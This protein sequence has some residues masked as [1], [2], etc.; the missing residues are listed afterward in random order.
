[1]VRSLNS[2]L[3]HLI[4]IFVL[5]FFSCQTKA[6][7]YKKEFTDTEK[8]QLVENLINGRG[9]YYQGT[10]A[11]Q[12]LLFEAMSYDS[13]HA[14]I[15]RELGV[16]YL[17]R[18]IAS[19]FPHYYG[20]AADLNPL[21]WLAW[22]GYLYLYFYRDYENA[23][24]D[25]LEADELTPGVVDYPQSLNIDFLKGI[26]YLKMGNHQN[27]INFFDKQINYES[28]EVGLEYMESIAF[29]Y[30]GIAHWEMGKK[31]TAKD[32]FEIGQKVDN[33]NADLLFWLAKYWAEKGNNKKARELI[34]KA[35][36][37]FLNGYFNKRNYTE[38]FYQT[39]LADIEE[40]EKKLAS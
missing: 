10:S 4:A 38:I 28:E 18:G 22:R 40:L 20:K 33:K 16:P 1:M 9:Y 12:F 25:F 11:E 3:N 32:I 8:K 27:A 30:K 31:E 34:A 5:M 15:Y 35:K 13:S 19:A 39:Y 29:L 17:K 24:K 26:C 36:Q 23:I 37:Q 6:P 2:F 21:D 7:L 14:D